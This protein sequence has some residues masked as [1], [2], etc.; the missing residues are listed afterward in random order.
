MPL[1]HSSVD[2]CL[3]SFPFF[4][5]MSNTI[6]TLATWCKELTHLKRLWCWERMKVGG[7]GDD[8]G[9]D[10]WMASPTQ[11]TWVW[12]DSGSWWWTGRPG[13]LRFMWSQR[14]RHD[15]S[16]ELI[17]ESWTVFLCGYMFSFPMGILRDRI[18]GS[19]G[20]TIFSFLRSFHQFSSVQSLSRVRLFAT[21]WITAR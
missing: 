14:V 10:G 7:E 4:N 16:T 8:R 6:N 3:G 13:V 2:E 18:A 20:N 19:C 1:I 11:W 21:P 5:F 17:I 9:W 12:V 15:W